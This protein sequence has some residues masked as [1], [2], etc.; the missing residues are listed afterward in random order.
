MPDDVLPL[1]R[2]KILAGDLPKLDCRMTWYGPGRGGLCV[3]CEQAIA[4]GDVEVECDLPDGGGTIRFHRSCY[5]VW[6]AEWP[7]FGDG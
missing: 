4:A 5:E 2:K 6:S 3:A 7:S 1:I